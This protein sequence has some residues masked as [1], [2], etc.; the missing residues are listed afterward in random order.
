MSIV[1][2]G[3][4]SLSQPVLAQD[5]VDFKTQIKPIFEE[6][7]YSCHGEKRQRGKLRLDLKAD[8]FKERKKPV[9]VPGDPAKSELY[10]LVSLPHD[11]VDIMP[12]DEDPLTPEQ[13]AL[14]KRWIE[15]GAEWP[16][17]ADAAPT[18]QAEKI[19][20]KQLNEAEKAAEA[21]AI[22]AISDVGGLAMRI[23]AD[24]NAVDVNLSLLGSAV[25]DDTIRKL[26]GLQHTLIWLN[27]AR[28]GVTDN[29]LAALKGF[30]ELRRLHLENTAIGD[31][32]LIHIA[33][34]TKLE[35]LNLYNTRVTDSGL[36]HLK[37]MKSLR[38]LYLWQTQVTEEGVKALQA[39]LPH[40]QIDVGN[41]RA[42]V[43]KADENKP[44]NAKCPVSGQPVKA[45]FV[46]THAEQVI[47]FCCGNCKAKF[48]ANPAEFVSKIPEF[49]APQAQAKPINAKCPLSGGDVNV[50]QTV[51]Y[52][53]QVIGFC[54]GNC[55]AKF[56]ANPA[57]HIGKVA[58]FKKG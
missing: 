27:L 35:Y 4:M 9:I 43:V 21:K 56:E 6:K 40:V 52:E 48:D 45:E 29:G 46:S 57:E 44:I 38:K 37:N 18:R 15:Q 26:D 1:A 54:C 7:C 16:D 24:S 42:V 34:L 11:D 33:G 2:G 19:E 13:L 55:K 39:A 12:P 41:Y 47:G 20:L 10:R 32:A 50:A 23:S 3:V 51:T 14:I 25:T 36:A 8:A 17:D 28:T 58:E 53:G 31:A 5:K 22:K 30:T 49:K